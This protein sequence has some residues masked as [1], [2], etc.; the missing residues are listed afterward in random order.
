MQRG[1]GKTRTGKVEHQTFQCTNGKNAPKATK[2]N[3]DGIQCGTETASR[4][5]NGAKVAAKARIYIDYTT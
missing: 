5:I 2:M 4:I 3:K 1:V